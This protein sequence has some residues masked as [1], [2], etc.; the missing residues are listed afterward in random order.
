MQTTDRPARLPTP[1]PTRGRWRVRFGRPVAGAVLLS[2]VTALLPG[3]AAAGAAASPPG[4]TSA[5]RGEEESPQ[6]R[7]VLDRVVVDADPT[8]GHA[9][10]TRIPTTWLRTPTDRI[11][12]DEDAVRDVPTGSTLAVRLTAPQVSA[13]ATSPRA[14]AAVTVLARASAATRTAPAASA[15]AVTVVLAL[16]AGTVANSMTTATLTRAVTGGVTRFWSRE[17]DGRITFAVAKAVGWTKLTSS[18]S[19]V[20]SVWDE[21]R[22]RVGF[23]PG[24]RRHLL[25]YAPSGTGCPTG[26]ATVG[27]TADTGGNVIVGGAATALVAHELGHNLGLG[28]SQALRCPGATDGVGTRDGFGSGCRVLPY[29][30]WYDVMGISWENLGTLSTAHAYRLGLL[31]TSAVVTTRGPARVTLR[32]VSTRVGIRSLRIQDPSGTTY[33]VEYR[34]ARGA[35]AWLGTADDWRGLQPGVLI[36]RTDPTDTAATLLLDPTLSTGSAADQDVDVAVPTGRTVTTA[37]GRISIV[38]E[39]VTPDAVTVA[40]SLDGVAPALVLQPHGRLVNGRQ[41]TIGQALAAWGAL[42]S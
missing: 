28:H 12:I 4:S 3:V 31:P 38:V 15:H 5:V 37:S 42:A 32:P 29:G 39:S 14:V 11:P 1:R 18:C 26:L 30:D 25:V 19:D 16:P 22:N 7:G 17:S 6:V 34:P 9:A 27:T 21:V 10:T 33:V 23:T 2:A 24:P 8:A 40:V 35:D 13:D 41:V 36:R 20:W